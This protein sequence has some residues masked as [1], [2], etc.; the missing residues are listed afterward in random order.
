MPV[1]SLAR[2]LG[3]PLVEDPASDRL[4]LVLLDLEM[5]VHAGGREPPRPRQRARADAHHRRLPG[6][7]GPGEHQ[8]S[9]RVRHPF[10]AAGLADL[11]EP[12]RRTR[13]RS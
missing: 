5:L 11:L 9:A 7:V 10:Q 13:P 1:A 4:S 3:P 12:D 8:A 6:H 2:L